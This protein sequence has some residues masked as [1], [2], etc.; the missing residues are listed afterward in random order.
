M[1]LLVKNLK[2]DSDLLA[3]PIKTDKSF[4]ARFAQYRAILI[5]KVDKNF[6]FFD[7]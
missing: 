2:L 6:S 7:H 1:L 4:I 3:L 5:K